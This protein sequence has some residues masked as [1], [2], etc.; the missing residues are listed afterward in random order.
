[1]HI[2]YIKTKEEATVFQICSLFFE[3]FSRKFCFFIKTKISVYATDQDYQTYRN[4]TAR[5]TA[6][7]DQTTF[8]GDV[9]DD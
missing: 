4:R 5:D 2:S 7:N 9:L 3:R 1:M 8:E 6:R